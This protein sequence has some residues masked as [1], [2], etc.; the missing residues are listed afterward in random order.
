MKKIIVSLCMAFMIGCQTPPPLKT[1]LEGK[2]MPS[3]TVQLTDSI[4]FLNTK[5]VPAGKPT[6]IFYFSP[7]CPFCKQEI[8]NIVDN[9]EK[10]KDLNFYLITPYPLKEMQ[11]FS[12]HYNLGQ[13]KNISMARDPKD[14][15]G[16]YFNPQ[17]YPFIAIY[18]KDKYLLQAFVGVTDSKQILNVVK[19]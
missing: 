4:T 7:R 10:L 18:N 8:K 19:G 3:F 16:K 2:P 11:A 15:F 14:S 5:N 1:G 6:I 13:Y 9:M 12:T 17:G